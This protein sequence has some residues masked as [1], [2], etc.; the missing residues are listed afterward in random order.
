M[1]VEIQIERGGLRRW[2]VWIAEELSLQR[3]SVRFTFVPQRR[4]RLSIP[5][6]GRLLLDFEA[7]I[8]RLGQQAAFDRVAHTVIDRWRSPA[9]ETLT[10]DVVIELAANGGAPNKSLP[11]TLS[12]ST[13]GEEGEMFAFS[14]LLAGRSFAL[15]VRDSSGS[16]KLYTA[17]PARD[18]GQPISVNLNNIY[19]RL[20]ELLVKAVA[21]NPFEPAAIA[22]R[23]SGLPYCD[24]VSKAILQHAYSRVRNYSA[25]K[26]SS[27]AHTAPRWSLALKN[28]VTGP[29]FQVL[30]DDGSSW[31]A[32][33]FLVAHK[34]SIFVLCEEFMMGGNKGVISA[35]ELVDGVQVRPLTVLEEDFHL[36]YPHVFEH[37]GEIW[38]I[39][40]TAQAEKVLLYRAVDFPHRWVREGV[41]LEGER[42]CDSTMLKHGEK[43]WL[44][45]TTA[46]WGGS[47]WDTLVVYSAPSLLGPWT[48][49][50]DSPSV[51]DARFS[52]SAGTI[53]LQ[54]GQ[55]FRPAQDCS[56]GYGSAINICRIDRLDLTSVVQTPVGRLSARTGEQDLGIHTSN[57]LGTVHAV[58]VFGDLQGVKVVEIQGISEPSI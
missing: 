1:R 34:G 22:Q 20:A 39:P 11:R 37:A 8:Y 14:Q 42:F 40:E 24:P 57:V 29:H 16:E 49:C 53:N 36:S 15:S 46:R 4:S 54:N 45:T 30:N 38:M 28:N 33:P 7:L 13:Q 21:D 23:D 47:S 26:I 55:I 18:P 5:S 56:R 6:V 31:R 41:L 3:H 52:R 35:F 17:L 9:S 48:Q 51:I 50:L 32:D 25:K 2:H 27:L 10:A 19:A 58:D 44:F 12:P 43:F